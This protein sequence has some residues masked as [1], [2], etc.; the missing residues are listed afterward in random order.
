MLLLLVPGV[1]ESGNG[2]TMV[3]MMTANMLCYMPTLGL[4]NSIA[5]ANLDRLAFPKVRVWGRSVGSLPVSWL[6]FLVGPPV[7]IS[8]IWPVPSVILGFLLHL[9]QYA[10]PPGVN[11]YLRALLMLDALAI[12]KRPP[13][14]SFSPAPALSVF[15][16]P[17]T[18]V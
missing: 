13:F 18:T 11:R 8:F 14:S 1:A 3:W 5:F 10:T 15:L 17:I 6:G 7:L 12:L 9:A 2:E 4:G 16:W